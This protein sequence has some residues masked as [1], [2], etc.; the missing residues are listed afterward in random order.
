M[1][2][3]NAEQRIGLSKCAEHPWCATMM[4]AQSAHAPSSSWSV[5]P[6]DC[7]RSDDSMDMSTGR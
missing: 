2:N 7:E 3:V 5:R 4:Q 1:L 6:I